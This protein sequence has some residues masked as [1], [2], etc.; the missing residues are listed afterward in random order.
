MYQA[1]GVVSS[2]AS[3]LLTL[4]LKTEIYALRAATEERKDEEKGGATG[5]APPHA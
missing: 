2:V 5:M 3:G 4:S 1:V